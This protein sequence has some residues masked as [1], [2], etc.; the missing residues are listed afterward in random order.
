MLVSLNN[1][2]QA[3]NKHHLL[4]YLMIYNDGVLTII[5]YSRYHIIIYRLFLMR[6]L[7]DLLS[8]LKLFLVLH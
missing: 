6:D 7:I 1:I 5:L 4:D 8:V 3:E 2:K